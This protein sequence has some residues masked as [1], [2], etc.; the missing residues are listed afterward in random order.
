MELPCQARP[1][2]TGEE[3]ETRLKGVFPLF[4]SIL[5]T[6]AAARPL[7][8]LERSRENIPGKKGAHELEGLPSPFT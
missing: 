7:S 3:G 4:Q 1:S 2:L 8:T 6:R 5:L